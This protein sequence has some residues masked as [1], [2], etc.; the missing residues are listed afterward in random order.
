MATAKLLPLPFVI[1]LIIC[2]AQVPSQLLTGTPSQFSSPPKQPTH[3]QTEATSPAE[4][5]TSP[6]AAESPAASP[7]PK[8]T[9]KKAAAEAS[10]TPTP[11]PVASP[12]P[13]KF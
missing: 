2:V 4:A 12:T 8:R 5:A 9:R 13:R 1:G 10:P 7:K 11:T 6:S 3:K